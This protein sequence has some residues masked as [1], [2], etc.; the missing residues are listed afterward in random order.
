MDSST[1]EKRVSSYEKSLRK[2]VIKASNF[3]TE[4]SLE[5][6]G[7]FS[8]CTN[9]CMTVINPK[10]DT[11]A[12]SY[13]KNVIMTE[14]DES[15][16]FSTESEKEDINVFMLVDLMNPN[17][18]GFFELFGKYDGSIFACNHQNLL[19]LYREEFLMLDI[20]KVPPLYILTCF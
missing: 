20:E 1:T 19:K 4:L 17:T 16:I 14:S 11:I 3:E 5:I 7:K 18:D 13:F 6:I 8:D 12:D 2:V 10:K 9:L 15:V